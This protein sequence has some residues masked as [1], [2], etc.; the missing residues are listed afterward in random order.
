[1][2]N[3]QQKQAESLYFQTDLSK[4]EIAK[5]IGISRRSLHYWMRDNNWEY[6]KKCTQTIPVQLAQNCYFIMAKL[7]ESIL[8][9]DRAGK[10]VTLQEVNAL[11]KLTMTINKL[12]DRCTLSENL[13][14]MAGFIEHVNGSSPATAEALAPV[15]ND[16]INAQAKG[17]PSKIMPEKLNVTAH[18]PIKEQDAAEAILD[19]EDIKAWAA[20]EEA[21]R[22]QPSSDASNRQQPASSAAGNVDEE[23]EN[24]IAGNTEKMQ[25]TITNP[26][27]PNNVLKGRHIS[28]AARRQM[29]RMAASRAA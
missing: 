14:M 15:V 16:Y 25:A 22:E 29:E 19:L 27:K 20:E 9:A 13:Q 10:P 12:K 4:T 24:E 17:T 8:S 2:K 5:M 21:Q 3:E 11:Y 23:M 26:T 28:R 1:M 18:L 6:I 7:Q